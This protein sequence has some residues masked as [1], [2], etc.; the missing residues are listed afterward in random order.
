ML[1]IAHAR[2]L[3]H[4]SVSQRLRMLRDGFCLPLPPAQPLLTQLFQLQTPSLN[5]RDEARLSE[6]LFAWDS[7]ENFL[8]VTTKSNNRL[9]KFV[10][11]SC[12]HV[13]MWELNA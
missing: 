5:Q 2:Q 12:K 9:C 13:H 8:F 10:L 7:N 11:H 1:F 3:G 6:R 4:V